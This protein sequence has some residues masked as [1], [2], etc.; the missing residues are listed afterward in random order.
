MTG[1]NYYS[2][3]SRCCVSNFFQ[4]HYLRMRTNK[5][6]RML[7]KIIHLHLH[8]LELQSL[9][10]LEA[11]YQS[12]GC[13]SCSQ[14]SPFSMLLII[15]HPSGKHGRETFWLPTTKE[16][17]PNGA[18]PGYWARLPK[19]IS[20][21]RNFYSRLGNLYTDES[22]REKKDP[23]TKSPGTYST[24]PFLTHDGTLVFLF[25]HLNSRLRVASRY[26]FILGIGPAVQT[27]GTIITFSFLLFTH[28]IFFVE[29]D[30]KD[31]LSYLKIGVNYLTA[32]C[33]K[34]FVNAPESGS[35][36]FF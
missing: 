5:W 9:L 16:E 31:R 25:F 29:K 6:E 12:A 11:H 13:L 30:I 32:G 22:I 3:L 18:R 10:S 1:V 17:I 8:T 21:A 34:R 27:W 14:S 35:S 7:I 24:V 2:I 26:S 20:C 19:R 23:G 15:Q 4:D 33:P 36:C 28:L